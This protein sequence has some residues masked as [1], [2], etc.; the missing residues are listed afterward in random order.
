MTTNSNTTLDRIAESLEKLTALLACVVGKETVDEQ[1]EFGEF[2]EY[3]F[4]T[5]RKR[6]VKQSTYKNDCKRLKT[7]I[8]PYLGNFPINGITPLMCQQLIDRFES[9]GKGK[10]A[11]EVFSLLNQIFKTAIKH[12]L[13][14]HNPLEIVIH[15]KHE[16]EHGKPLTADEEKQL[17]N[18][19][20]EPYRTLFAIGLYTGVRPNEYRT[21]RIEGDIVIAKNSKRHSDKEAEK[22]IPITPMLRPYI[23]EETVIYKAS[24]QQLRKRFKKIF[25]DAHKLYD[26]RTTFYTRCKMCD[27]APPARDEFMGHSSGE[28]ENAYTQLPDS[29]LIKEA[30]KLCY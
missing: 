24:E 9:E 26:L 10:T 11:E 23:S 1:K 13:I 8:L 22:R 16:R 21:V 27:V 18:S 14:Q 30:Q 2:A 3:Y 17:L 5:F 6:K 25:G 29:Y 28:I 15:C 7:N 4:E 12:N 20:A 19:A